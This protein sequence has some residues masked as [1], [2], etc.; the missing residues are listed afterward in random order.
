MFS[1]GIPIKNVIILMI[2]TG[3]GG[4]LKVS[5][6]STSFPMI[7]EPQARSSDLIL[8]IA[9]VGAVRSTQ[10]KHEEPANFGVVGLWPQL[11]KQIR[12]KPSRFP[13][14]GTGGRH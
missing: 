9:L 10:Q 8:A 7:C 1:S 2:V 4:E 6:F 13:R 3:K 12:L 5:L 14:F 11:W